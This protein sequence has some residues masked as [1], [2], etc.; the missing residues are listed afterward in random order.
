MLARA[1]LPVPVVVKGCV[2]VVKNRRSH[3]HD[4][5]GSVRQSPD[6]CPNHVI[7]LYGVYHATG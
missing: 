3:Y 4:I 1:V 6:T 7:G 2:L 5:P